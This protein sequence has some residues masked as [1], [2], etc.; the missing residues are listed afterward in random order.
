MLNKN[1]NI[2]N[3][4]T[5]TYPSDDLGQELNDDITFYDLFYC[6]DHYH[7]VYELLG[8]IDSVVRERCFQALATIMGVNYEY[9]FE[10]W[11]KCN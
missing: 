5:E 1:T 3:W 2:K 8:D 11:L 6:L 4:Y 9:I 10:Q 7:D